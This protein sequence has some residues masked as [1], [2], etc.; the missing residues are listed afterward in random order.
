MPCIVQHSELISIVY[1]F[2]FFPV[3][4]SSAPSAIPTAAPTTMSQYGQVARYTF[5]NLSPNDTSGNGNHGVCVGMTGTIDR[6]G[7]PNNAGNFDGVG[8][9][10]KVNPGTVFSFNTTFTISLWL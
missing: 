9:F 4:Q 6:F 1:F 3:V 7:A 5:D 2:H 8:S 10:F